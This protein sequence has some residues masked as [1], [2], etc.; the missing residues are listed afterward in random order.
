MAQIA[1]HG[2]VSAGR[3]A[4]ETLKKL[5]DGLK[6]PDEYARRNAMTCIREIIKHE[7]EQAN[8]INKCGGPAPIIK[9]ITETSGAMRLPGV[10]ALRHYVSSDTANAK[11]VIDNNGIFPLKDA[12]VNDPLIFV[13]SA[14]AWTLGEIARYSVEYAAPIVDAD[15]HEELRRAA[16]SIDSQRRVEEIEQR[17]K[18]EAMGKTGKDMTKKTVKEDEAKGGGEE[19]KGEEGKSMSE[20]RRDEE[21]QAVM[22]TRED[23]KKKVFEALGKILEN[24]KKHETMID[25][26]LGE[27]DDLK[28]ESTQQLIKVVLARLA[29]LIR[30]R[31][32]CWKYGFTYMM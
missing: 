32:E 26:F 28:N 1:K 21:K 7:G 20:T 11:A 5:L 10:V 27:I 18:A 14:A 15:I 24:C 4:D 19:G 6:D 3:I 31:G 9:Y 13:R 30:E 16:R 25:I 29:T 8:K 23:M 17:R 2:A 22:M 12:L